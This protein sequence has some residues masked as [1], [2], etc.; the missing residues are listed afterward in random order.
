MDFRLLARSLRAR[1]TP[2]LQHQTQLHRVAFL[3]NGVRYNSSTSSPKP[4]FK[5]TSPT[6]QPSTA[7]EAAKQARKPVS[8]FDDILSRL[9][10][11]K[12]REAPSSQRRIFSDSL[13]RAVGEG[14]QS[15]YRARSRAP[16]PTRKVELKLGPTLGRQVHVEPE[17]GT[18]LGA[19]LRK[20][21]ATLSQNSVRNDAHSQKFHVR[22]GMVRKQQ[23]MMRWKKLFKFSFQGTVKK[24]Q[25]MQAQGW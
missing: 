19:A 7:P 11:N 3:T 18:D 13:S 5:P 9:D 14:A 23:K 24:I 21:Q 6:D 25:R 22:K 15:S 12:P 2:C 1:P 4:P 16:L 17:R 8:D 20:L 10:L